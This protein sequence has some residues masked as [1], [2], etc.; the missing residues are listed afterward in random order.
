MHYKQ[1]AKAGPRMSQVDINACWR[2]AV[3]KEK[4]GRTLNETFTFNPK[5]LIA[6]TEKPTTVV[7][8]KDG[9]KEKVKKEC[10]ALQEKLLAT[11]KTPKRKYSFPRTSSMDIGWDMD[12][13]MKKHEPKG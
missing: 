13:H 2:E 9:E 1:D 8:Y 12:T 7:R 10:K 4:E 5:N 6:I 11:Y 3:R